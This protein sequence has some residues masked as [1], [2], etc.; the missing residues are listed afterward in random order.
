MSVLYTFIAVLTTRHCT[1]EINTTTTT[2]MMQ[3]SMDPTFGFLD[4]A[5]FQEM[6][7]QTN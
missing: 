7:E 5:I 1:V 3:T 2:I 4:I 6:T